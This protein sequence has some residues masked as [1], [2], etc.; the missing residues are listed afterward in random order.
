MKIDKIEKRVTQLQEVKQRKLEVMAEQ[1]SHKFT[2]SIN[3]KSDKMAKMN[4]NR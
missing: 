4:E 3:S 2:P 1:A